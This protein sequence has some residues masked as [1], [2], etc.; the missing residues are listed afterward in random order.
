MPARTMPKRRTPLLAP[1][2]APSAALLLLLL[3]LA[4]FAGPAQPDKTNGNDAISV[5]ANAASGHR[6]IHSAAPSLTLMK[7]DASSEEERSAAATNVQQQQQQQ[8][9]LDFSAYVNDFNLQAEASIPED[10]FDQHDA[11]IGEDA[12]AQMQYAEPAD[13]EADEYEAADIILE[14]QRPTSRN[15][16]VYLAKDGKT[17]KKKYHNN[18][19]GNNSNNNNKNHYSYKL[20]N[21][22]ESMPTK[23]VANEEEA[24]TKSTSGDDNDSAKDNNG[25]KNDEVD[26]DNE[27]NGNGYGYGY[28]YS[29]GNEN[30]AGAGAGTGYGD[31]DTGEDNA[32]DGKPNANFDSK[33]FAYKKFKNMHEQ[34]NQQSQKEQQQQTK[35]QQQQQHQQEQANANGPARQQEQQERNAA[36]QWQRE[37]QQ[38]PAVEQLFDSIEILNERKFNKALGQST[39]LAAE[40]VAGEDIMAIGDI[41][42]NFGNDKV[43]AENIKS[44]IDNDESAVSKEMIM[45]PAETSTTATPSASTSTSTTPTTSST[46]TTPATTT[47]QAAT[48]P[49]APS[50]SSSRRDLLAPIGRK[51]KRHGNGHSA[52]SWPGSRSYEKKNY[53]IGRLHAA[54]FEL[55]AEDVGELHYYDGEQHSRGSDDGA[56][57]TETNYLSSYLGHM[58]NGTKQQQHQQKK[59]QKQ[60]QLQEQQEQRFLDDVEQQGEQRTSQLELESTLRYQPDATTA[61]PSAFERFKALRRSSRR[62]GHKSHKKRYKDYLKHSSALSVKQRKDREQHAQKWHQQRQLAEKQE[63]EQEKERER[64]QQ[65][66]QQQQEQQQEK[67]RERTEQETHAHASPIFALGVRPQRNTPKPFYEGQVNYYDHQ[68]EQPLQPLG[69]HHTEMERLIASDNDN[70]YRRISPVLRNG[71]KSTEMHKQH[72]QQHQA[73]HHHHL[74]HHYHQHHHHKHARQRLPNPYQR[75]APAQLATPPTTPQPPLPPPKPQL[76]H[77]ITELEQLER[78]YAKWPHLARVQF[79]VYDEH[80]REAH[81]ELYGDY[82]A[83]DDYETA[84][85]LEEA[86]QDHGAEA[87]LPPYIKKYNRRNKQLLNLLEGTL[88]PP[89]ATPF[90][91]IWSGS[92]LQPGPHESAPIRVDDD[93]V[94]QKR[95]RYQQRYE[96]VFAQQHSSSSS[97]GVGSGSGS[98][99]TTPATLSSSPA[100]QLNQLPEEDKQLDEHQLTAAVDFWQR[101]VETKAGSKPPSPHTST[102]KPALYK[103]PLYPAIAGSFLGTPRSRSAQ[104][105]ANV[106]GRGQGS[107]HPAAPAAPLGANNHVDAHNATA[108]P[109]SP[110]NSFVY[111][112]VVDGIGAASSLSS[113]SLSRKQRLPFVAITDRR[114]ESVG[115][116]KLAG[117]QHK[118]LEQNHFP[119]P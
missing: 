114:L 30:G 67:Q 51:P 117:E 41:E 70:W 53:G 106:S 58:V 75:K 21:N 20:K 17:V 100:S 31:E 34:Q 73:N 46:S 44:A 99:T 9:R 108:P 61:S 109:F 119:M 59:E 87:N 48:A 107:W 94:K 78:Y 85:E 69:T 12:A 105:V 101:E 13:D 96:D 50:G 62:N 15:F 84:A 81:P 18:N 79:Q 28:G 111:H 60:P 5:A 80:Y 102:S 25:K 63:R 65:K 38:Q 76:G 37:Q 2:P 89:T 29:N 97:S 103:L 45:S 33:S 72:Q 92:Q 98:P 22:K 3:Q 66:Q 90:P 82:D 104:F 10:I 27:R 91:G 16:T 39:L 32:E 8:Q 35:Q 36:R 83:D 118:E 47:T 93:Y 6:H 115:A 71:I 116:H 64:E 113:S 19:N 23:R 4:L 26:S 112:R 77:Q 56:G 7:R 57:K 86:Q 24:A 14:S 110:L 74:K 43:L 49:A 11:D 1:L 54:D 95:R 88:P 40:D 55:N 52:M 42:D 68:E